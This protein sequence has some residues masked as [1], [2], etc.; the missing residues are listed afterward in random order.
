[1]QIHELIGLKSERISQTLSPSGAFLES[2]TLGFERLLDVASAN[3][4]FAGNVVKASDAAGLNGGYS[5]EILG[6]PSKQAGEAYTIEEEEKVSGLKDAYHDLLPSFGG[7]PFMPPVEI[8]DPPV[9]IYDPQVEMLR[10]ARVELKV[11]AMEEAGEIDKALDAF[12]G[13]HGLKDGLTREGRME[14]R[15]RIINL[16]KAVLLESEWREAYLGR[17]TERIDVSIEGL[18]DYL[19]SEGGTVRTMSVN[20]ELPYE[21][22]D[23]LGFVNDQRWLSFE[24]P[25]FS[26]IAKADQM[27]MEHRAEKK[28]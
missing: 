27:L 9:E 1:M 13:I 10:L 26:L 18:R 23:L 6:V 3:P 4:R 14:L 24:V 7:I 8:Y 16:T 21:D 25:P 15:D 19:M 5:G 11:Q 20:E 12:I 22:P 2:P 17:I 28:R